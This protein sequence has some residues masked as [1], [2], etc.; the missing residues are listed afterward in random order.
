MNWT[1]LP[2]V[3]LRK[4]SSSLSLVPRYVRLVDVPLPSL[5]QSLA[6]LPQQARKNVLHKLLAKH[7]NELT[8]KELTRLAAEVE[9]YSFSDIT[10]LAKDAALG[11]IR[12][13]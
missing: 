3:D 9:G 5:F 11:P 4:E 8:D 13:Q 7:N 2:S 12:G 1:T 6:S 10:A